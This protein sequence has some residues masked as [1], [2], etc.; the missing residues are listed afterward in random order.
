MSGTIFDFFIKWIIIIIIGVVIKLMDDYLDQDLDK[1]EGEYTLAVSLDK[2]IVPYTLLCTVMCM[3]VAP[4]LSGSLF[5]AS[6]I[7]GMGHDLKRVLPFGWTAL[8][9][10]ILFTVFGLLVFEPREMFSSLLVILFIQIMDDFLDYYNDSRFSR[11]NFVV[12]FGVPECILGAL[13]TFLGAVFLD[14]LKTILVTI[15][16]PIILFGM[17]YGKRWIKR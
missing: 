15:S 11:R 10:A 12:R 9:E 8:K 6:Y 14:P 3:A 7:I 13:I 2:A 17:G 4:V 1:I 16:T 5:L